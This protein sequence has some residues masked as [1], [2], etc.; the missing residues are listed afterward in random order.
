MPYPCP[1]PEIRSGSPTLQADSLPSESPGRAKQYTLLLTYF[2]DSGL[3]LLIPYPNLA[4]LPFLS[5]MAT[6]SLFPLLCLFLFCY[7]CLYYFWIP[8]VSYI[9]QYLS[10][11]LWLILLSL[12]FST[13]SALTWCKW[14]AFYCFHGCII[15]HGISTTSLSIHL[16]MNPQVFSTALLL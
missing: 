14:Q 8:H 16:W 15:F 9:I 7:I 6:T 10:Y 2:V 4:H 3:C 1:D 13:P 5:P 12:V 11:T